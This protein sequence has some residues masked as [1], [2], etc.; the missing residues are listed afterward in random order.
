MATITI[1]NLDLWRIS[2]WEEPILCEVKQATGE[3]YMLGYEDE[4][5]I[6]SLHAP[7]KCREFFN[8]ILCA[9]EDVYQEELYG[10]DGKTVAD[11]WDEVEAAG[12]KVRLFVFLDKS[13]SIEKQVVNIREALSKFN[14]SFGMGEAS[15]SYLHKW[16]VEGLDEKGKKSKRAYCVGDYVLEIRFPNW[17]IK[18]QVVFNLYG[19]QIREGITKIKYDQ[20]NFYD[21][22]EAGIDYQVRNVYA[23][24]GS[25]YDKENKEIVEKILSWSSCEDAFRLFGITYHEESQYPI[26][27]LGFVD[28]V[29]LHKEDDGDIRE[30]YF[31]NESNEDDM[32]EG[33]DWEEEDIDE[34]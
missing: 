21:L 19:R 16:D 7:V 18:N 3:R 22:G 1:G 31:P 30:E 27:Q 20:R 32:W 14:T 12:Q 8:D 4:N 28:I 25:I 2:S 33:G 11:A 5:K 23:K 13:L 9:R 15:R 26:H 6:F 10:L 34:F 29:K 24:V 17:A